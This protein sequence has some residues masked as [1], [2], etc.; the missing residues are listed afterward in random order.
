M[1]KN[2]ALPVS[3]P[4]PTKYQKYLPLLRDKIPI[5][6]F[7]LSAKKCSNILKQVKISPFRSL[8]S[9]YITTWQQI[10]V[11]FPVLSCVFM[12]Y[13]FS[14][15][16]SPRTAPNSAGAPAC[17]RAIWQACP[18]LCCDIRQTTAE[19]FL[20]QGRAAAFHWFQVQIPSRW[21]RVHTSAHRS[22]PRGRGRLYL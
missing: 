12:G 18:L 8:V 14:F 13:L 3:R 10:N 21:A 15:L 20:V 11:D 17:Y 1:L 19:N 4:P 7:L 9:G 5:F 22:L 16:P 6:F 2:S